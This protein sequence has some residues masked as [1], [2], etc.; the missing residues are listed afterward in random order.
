MS[1]G[2]YLPLWGV[3]IALALILVNGWFAAA[4]KSI[5]E[6]NKVKIRELADDGNK[7]AARALGY[8]LKQFEGE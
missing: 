4:R 8:V 7:K 2:P 6:A 1:E 3:V 5:S